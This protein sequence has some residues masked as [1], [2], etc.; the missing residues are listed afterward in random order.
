MQMIHMTDAGV[1]ETVTW[2][3]HGIKQLWGTS[4][5]VL[6]PLAYVWSYKANI[7][8]SF[9]FISIPVNGTTT[10]TTKLI[11]PEFHSRTQDINKLRFLWK[12][13]KYQQSTVKSRTKPRHQLIHT[14]IFRD[15]RKNK[16]V[17]HFLNGDNLV[18]VLVS[19]LV[20]RGKLERKTE[21]I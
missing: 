10:T 15:W 21:I 13:P 5:W 19:G 18:G 20:N 14:D 16:T 11:Q 4:R 17:T 12:W 8:Y 1:A 2:E 9:L 6:A 3:D 7:I